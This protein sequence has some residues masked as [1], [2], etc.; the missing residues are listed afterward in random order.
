MSDLLADVLEAHGGL[1]RWNSL[2]MVRAQVVSGGDLFTVKGVPQ[3]PVPREQTVWLH[4]EH[5][6]ITP[7]GAVGRKTDFT[8]ERVSIQT[9]DGHTLVEREDPRASFAGHELATPWDAVDR[10]YFNGYAMWTYFTTPF[11]FAMPGFQVA[12]IEPWHEGDQ[13]WRGLRVT[14]PEGN[15]SHSRQQEFYFGAD[16]LLRRH[17]YHVDIAGGFA[18]AQYVYGIVDADG[19]R[20]PTVRRAFR[21][22]AQDRPLPGLVMVSIDI[23]DVRF[24]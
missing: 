24:S 17:D 13:V 5:A 11:L 2:T 10:A 4:Q 1:T 14:F 3:D 18:A 12:E 19:I 8:P 22:D 23:S 9:L 20:L 16:N 15:P 21:R 6:S 7:Y